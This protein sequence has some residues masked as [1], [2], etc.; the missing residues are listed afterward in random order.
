[1]NDV[2][3]FPGAGAAGIVVLLA[4]ED[5]SP[6]LPESRSNVTMCLLLGFSE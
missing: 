3:F 1:M 2:Y 5:D 6:F 4:E